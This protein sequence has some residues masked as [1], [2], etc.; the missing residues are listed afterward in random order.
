MDLVITKMLCDET[1]IFIAIDN[2]Q[3]DHSLA[4]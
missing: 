3:K 4:F 2:N 1:R